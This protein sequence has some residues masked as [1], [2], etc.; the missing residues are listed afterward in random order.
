MRMG[1]KMMDKKRVSVVIDGKVY[2][3]TGS[4]SEAHMQRVA[5]YVDSKLRE[6]RVQNSYGKLFREYK[7]VLLSLNIAEELFL[8]QDELQVIRQEHMENEKE[9]YRLKQEI[10]D[11]EMRNDTA[12]KLVIEYKT[13]VNDLQKR[14]IELETGNAKR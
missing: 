3:L 4:E 6:I 7:N 13:K 10:V 12:N 2:V 11:K 9:L 1:D 5:S 14:I 8:L